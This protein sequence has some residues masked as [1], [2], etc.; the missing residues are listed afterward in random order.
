MYDETDGDVQVFDFEEIANYLLEQGSEVSPAEIHGCLSGLLSAGARPLPELGLN[1]MGEAID[2]TA[3][4]ELADQIM[5]LYDTTAAALTDEE[6][7]F[8]PLLPEE[9]ADIDLRTT[10]LANWCQGFLAGFAQMRS[11]PANLNRE[12][13][14]DAREI[15]E[16]IAAMSQATV[17]EEESAD[18]SE[19]S[20]VEVVEYLRFAVINLFSEQHALTDGEFPE[21]GPQDFLH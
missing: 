11:D 12:W 10:A 19:G 6:Y 7:G 17:G 14:S 5:Q 18:E 4:G 1:K 8:Y 13:S 21:P 2:L 20:Y 9:E 15:L 16:D 3:H